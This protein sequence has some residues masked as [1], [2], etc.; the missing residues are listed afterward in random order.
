MILRSVSIFI[1]AALLIGRLHA[2]DFVVAQS[3]TEERPAGLL[4]LPEIFGETPCDVSEAKTLDFYATPSKQRA[5]IGIIERLNPSRGRDDAECNQALVV[6]RLISDN[7]AER[8]PTDE[9]GYEE[10]KAVVYEHSGDWFRIALPRGSAWIER[11]DSS[12]FLSYPEQLSGESFLTYLRAGW[13]GQIWTTPGVGPA[14]PAP[15]PWR[16]LV[17]EQIPVR[18]TSTQVVRGEKWI[19][20]FLEAESCGQSFG[21]LPPLEAWLPAYRSS[22]DTSI[23]FYSRGC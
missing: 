20:V 8:L 3:Q 10:V 5:P 16:A 19:H 11:P 7:T 9:S 13:D 18:V 17:K 22:R 6:V 12:G 2:Q 14:A 4:A 15:A 21:N 23:W 1:F